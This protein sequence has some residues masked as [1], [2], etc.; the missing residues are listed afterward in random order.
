[1]DKDLII[2]GASNY[3]WHQ[4]QYWVNSIKRT[5]FEGEIVLCVSNIDQTTV[6]KLTSEGV[7]VA[8][9]GQKEGDRYVDQVGAPHVKRFFYIWDYLNRNKD[10]YR[11]VLMTDTRDVVFQ[12]DPTKYLDENLKLHTMVAS[13]EGLLYKDEP[14]GD[15]NLQEALGP[16]FHSIYRENMIYN[17]GTIAGFYEDVRDFILMLFQLSI[18]R[19]TQIVDQAMFNFMISQ[20]PYSESI[21][22]TTNDCGWAIQ[23]GTTRPAVESGAGDLGARGDMESYDKAYQDEQPVINGSL[24]TNQEGTPFN[25]VHQWDRVPS[26]KALIEKEYGDTNENILTIRTV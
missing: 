10:Q 11:F 13:S 14:W 20:V 2:G 26:L 23:L 7:K 6:D 16:Y 12:K 4:L 15:N 22:K 17:V 24:V 5:G 25:I 18:N 8:L 3:S 9:Y 19:P 1:M 21:L